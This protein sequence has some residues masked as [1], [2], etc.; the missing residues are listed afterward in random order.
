MR[1]ARMVIE[2]VTTVDILERKVTVAKV[3][4]KE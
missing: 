3:V 2:R 1:V 4:M